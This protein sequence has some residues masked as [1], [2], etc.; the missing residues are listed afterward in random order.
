MTPPVVELGHL[1]VLHDHPVEHLGVFESAAHQGGRGHRRAVV[2]E[3][4]RA[5]GDEL[6]ELGQLFALAALADGADGIDVGL[7]RP[8]GLQD[9]E[10]GRGLACRWRD[11]CWAC[12]PPTS[13]RRPGRRWLPWRWSRPPRCP[14]R[15]DGR[16][17]RSSPGRRSCPWASITISASS[18]PPP[19]GRIRPRLIQRSPISS[20]ILRRD[21]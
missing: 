10:L 8:L 15:E 9:D 13:R 1:A 3:G 6:A 4:D 2:G 5:A 18:Y 7:P 16:E 17:R 20:S 11:W 14:A 12:R 19:R 21:R